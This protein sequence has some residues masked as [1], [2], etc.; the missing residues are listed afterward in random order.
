M[1]RNRYRQTRGNHRGT[2]PHVTAWAY[3]EEFLPPQSGTY[4]HHFLQQVAQSQSGYAML[5]FPAADIM[6]LMTAT[7]VLK[8]LRL[9]RFKCHGGGVMKPGK[10]ISGIIREPLPA[11]EAEGLVAQFK[12]APMDT[13]H[14]TMR[15]F[16]GH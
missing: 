9:Q 6:V 2:R 14:A 10:G 15:P 7:H 8:T 12:G 13:Q 5:G 16:H 4:F 1:L 3:R 11:L